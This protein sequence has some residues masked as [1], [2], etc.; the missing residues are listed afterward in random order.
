VL[1]VRSKTEGLLR[2]SCCGV[3]I[4]LVLTTGLA[5]VVWEV[6]LHHS[7]RFPRLSTVQKLR[8]ST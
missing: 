8:R 4:L 3:L 2:L 7:K 1:Q 6:P 5:S